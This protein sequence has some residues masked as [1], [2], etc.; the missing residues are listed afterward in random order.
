MSQHGLY[1]NRRG[2]ESRCYSCMRC[3]VYKTTSCSRHSVGLGVECTKWLGMDDGW[4][5]GQCGRSLEVYIR[6]AWGPLWAFL[7][8]GGD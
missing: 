4:S 7:W 3:C 6:P 8:L 1:D 2:Y 5:M